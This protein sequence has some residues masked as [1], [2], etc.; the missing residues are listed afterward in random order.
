MSHSV[1]S[2]VSPT[3]RQPVARQRRGPADAG[4]FWATLAL[5]VFGLI[6]LYSA[7]AHMALEENGSQFALVG[8]QLFWILSG[9]A[10]MVLVSRQ[11]YNKIRGWSW[12]FA[13]FAILLLGLTLFKGVT[14]NGSERWLALGPI[15]FQPS[16]F[17]KLAIVLILADVLAYN[18]PFNP[19]GRQVAPLTAAIALVIT[20]I[21]LIYKQP[22]LSI[23]ALLTV[24]ASAM[25][26]V[27]GL[28]LAIVAASPLGLAWVA[29]KVMQTPYQ[30]RRI[31]GWVNPW[32]DPQDAG[33]NL[34]QSWFAIGSGGFFGVGFGQSVQK[35]F[36]LPFPYTDFIFSVI[37][38]EMGFLGVAVTLLLYGFI[39]F[40]GYRIAWQCSSAYGQLLAFGLTTVLM[41]Q[42]CINLGVATGVF[43]VTGVT[44]PLISYG[45]T[46]VWVSL[47]LIGLLLSISRTASSVKSPTGRVF[48]SKTIKLAPS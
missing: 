14:T 11:S 40:R 30:M 36:Y 45:G 34:L 46:S 23:A 43:P 17:A 6:S 1:H 13:I 8:K 26:F 38:E 28:P 18:D 4:L 24:T 39:G 37:C 33:Y 41:V 9:L 19:K 21:L 25:A 12:I 7:S 15:Q 20:M 29:Y 10:L 48:A 5:C 2:T 44:L 3:T 22:N 27:A 35:L 31:N 32:A 47:I 42:A 16:E